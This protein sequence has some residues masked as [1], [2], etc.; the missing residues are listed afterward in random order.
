MSLIFLSGPV[1]K[2]VRTGRLSAAVR[3]DQAVEF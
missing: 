2:T 1:T 3:L